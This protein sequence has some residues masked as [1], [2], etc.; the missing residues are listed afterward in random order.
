MEAEWWGHSAGSTAVGSLPR[1][2]TPIPSVGSAPPKWTLG[3]LLSGYTDESQPLVVA[4]MW[5]EG[6]Y[7]GIFFKRGG[8]GGAEEDGDDGEEG[9]EIGHLLLGFRLPIFRPESE[10]SLVSVEISDSES[11]TDAVKGIQYL[12]FAYR[13]EELVRGFCFWNVTNVRYA[14]RCLKEGVFFARVSE[15]GILAFCTDIE[16]ASCYRNRAEHFSWILIS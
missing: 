15:L 13:Y 9:D 16:F 10:I 11:D 8:G 5:R 12:V 1:R 2:H 7:C 6:E 14:D 4:F 3:S